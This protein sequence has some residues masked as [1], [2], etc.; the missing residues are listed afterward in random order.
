VDTKAIK[1]NVKRHAVVQPETHRLIPLTRGQNA[2]VDIEDFDWLSQWNWYAEWSPCS[3]SYYAARRDENNDY[4][5]MHRIITDAPPSKEVDHDNHDTLDNR[6]DNLRVCSRQ[7]NR[8]NQGLRSNNT[9][10]FKGVSWS[11]KLSK[12]WGNI[13]INGKT[14]HLGYFASKEEAARAYDEA[15]KKHFGE[16]AKLN[17]DAR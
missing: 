11:K 1:T 15:A 17:F 3:H 10:G 13:R 4:V 7:Q 14:L 9:S 2:I 12:W 6:R 5:S 8:F 16:F